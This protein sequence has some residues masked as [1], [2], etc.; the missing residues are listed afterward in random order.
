[1]PESSTRR[2]QGA[3]TTTKKV[4]NDPAEQNEHASSLGKPVLPPLPT[5]EE[6]KSQALVTDTPGSVAEEWVKE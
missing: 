3:G 2:V 4:R 5:D 6:M 1:M